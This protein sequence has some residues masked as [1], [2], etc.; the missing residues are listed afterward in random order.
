M[1]EQRRLSDCDCS[2]D[3][4]D[5]GKEL[6]AI[7]TDEITSGGL[8]DSVDMEDECLAQTR[9]TEK[10]PRPP[11]DEA[12][13]EGFSTVQ[14]K[15]NTKRVA[16]TLS[17]DNFVEGNEIQSSEKNVVVVLTA[18]TILPKQVGMAKFLSSLG[19][20]N[21][22]KIKSMGV[23][24]AFITFASRTDAEKLIG[25]EELVRRE[26]RCHID[27]IRYTYGIVREI[28]VDMDEKEILNSFS[29][30][31]L[32]IASVR[33]LNRLNDLGEWVVSESVRFAFK[34]SSLP[35]YVQAYGV[36]FKVE[37]YTFPVTQCS[38]CWSFGHTLKFC[39]TKKTRC[40]KC[41]DN[42][43][44]CDIAIYTCVNCKGPHMALDKCCP[45]FLKEKKIRSIMSQENVTYKKALN[46]CIQLN[47]PMTVTKYVNDCVADLQQQNP[48]SDM[49]VVPVP[50]SQTTTYRDAVLAKVPRESNEDSSQQKTRPKRPTQDNSHKNAGLKEPKEKKKQR[51]VDQSS[52]SSS[53]VEDKVGGEEKQRS[54]NEERYS[55]ICLMLK[56]IKDLLL[57]KSSLQEK[58]I[59]VF[60]VVVEKFSKFITSIF[61]KGEVTDFFLS[62]F[63]NG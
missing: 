32:E 12:D 51:E 28:D 34:S 2:N 9:L 7:P 54:L 63:R 36:P 49:P 43:Q 24:K 17:K 58:I 45:I 41:G 61:A 60:M 40:P 29:C 6:E 55:W 10:R 38:G 25:S 4:E 59:G 57:S 62:L 56:K 5:L 42:H 18:K 31:S 23:N 33:R 16:R 27:D 26:Y 37:S 1:D 22:L 21:I 8:S 44:N 47:K 39:R 20:K 53:E 30:D 11:S 15:R 3:S 35:P 14:R 46:S 13:D 19:V 50:Q 52:E 48:T